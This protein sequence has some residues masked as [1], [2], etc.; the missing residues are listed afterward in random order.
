MKPKLNKNLSL[1]PWTL[2]GKK[3]SGKPSNSLPKKK[4]PHLLNTIPL[5]DFDLYRFFDLAGCTVVTN[6]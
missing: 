4:L 3:A 5:S 2:Q 1:R 6:T